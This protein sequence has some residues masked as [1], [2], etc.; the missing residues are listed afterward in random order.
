ML[1]GWLP[2]R[3]R[4][5]YLALHISGANLCGVLYDISYSSGV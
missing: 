5:S 3:V 2:C 4:A 1:N